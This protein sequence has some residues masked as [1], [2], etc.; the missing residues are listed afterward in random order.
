MDTNPPSTPPADYLGL[1]EELQKIAGIIEQYP[2]QLKQRA[3]ELLINAY[4]GRTNSNA[5]PA[6]AEAGESAATEEPSG[7]AGEEVA[8][9]TADEPAADGPPPETLSGE[10]SDGANGDEN[11]YSLQSDGENGSGL[12]SDSR[13]TS[14]IENPTDM[15]RKR[16]RL[17]TMSQMPWHQSS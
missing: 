12:E 11:G 7:A 10:S 4:L 3:F 8:S 5:S 15:L 1:K 2:D 9:L 14:N 17:R 16:I 13:I 6:P